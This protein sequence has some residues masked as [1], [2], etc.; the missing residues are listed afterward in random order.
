MMSDRDARKSAALSSAR[1]WR[2][3][4]RSQ[5]AT[6]RVRNGPPKPL[7]KTS[8]RYPSDSSRIKPTSSRRAGRS[9]LP[10]IETASRKNNATKAE[11]SDDAL[12]NPFDKGSF[13]WVA[14]GKYIK[15][16]RAG[17]PCVCKWFIGGGQG[18][19]HERFFDLD[20]KAMQKSYQIVKEWNNE[21]LIDKHVKVNIPEVWTF[22]KYGGHEISG[23]KVLL[24]PFIENYTKFNSNNGWQDNGSHWSRVM[25]ALSHFSYHVSNGEFL[26]CDLQG[27]VYKSTIVL[28]DPVI[29]SRDQAYG[30]TDLGMQGISS[31]FAQHECNEYCCRSWKKPTNKK[32]Y[33]YLS[34]STTMIKGS[35][36]SG[37]Y[38]PTCGPTYQ[39]VGSSKTSQ[40]R[41]TSRRY[42]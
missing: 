2:D 4:R 20:I 17:E 10:P 38:V 8:T 23:K 28:T 24:E 26:L 1:K 36:F 40:R 33:L 35:G 32:Q 3:E 22:D 6:E 15:G 30:V 14:K 27:G 7:I 37:A 11:F 39:T 5:A 12:D 16:A 41:S 25:Q 9:T 34:Q 13:R 21:R 18:V 31:F 19:D 29:L 42:R